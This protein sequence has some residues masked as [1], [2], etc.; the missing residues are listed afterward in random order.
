[1]KR[2][3]LFI[4]LLAAAGFSVSCHKDGKPQPDGNLI[5]L[6][7]QEDVASKALLNNNTFKTSGNRVHVLDVL[8]GFTGSA[9][10]AD[11]N[12]E[13]GG[14]YINDDIVYNGTVVWDYYSGR[15]YPWTADG[16]HQFFGWLSYDT[17][18]NLTADSYFGTE[19]AGNFSV[20]DRTL[21]IPA[22][23]MTTDSDQFDF[24][25][26]N[27]AYY[28]MPRTSTDP[29]NL[30][31]Q[32]LFSAISIQLKNESQD[33]ILVKN[34]TIEG[35]KNKKSAVI[36]FVG[37]PTLTTL[38]ASEEFLDNL[39]YYALHDTTKTLVTDD[40]IDLLTR[41]KNAGTA[42]YRLIWPQT[43]AELAPS[44]VNDLTT[45]PIT[46]SYEYLSDEEHV[47]HTA[48]LRFPEDVSF[49]PGVRYAFTLLFTQKHIQL[50][51]KV[52]PWNYNLNEWSFDEQS[53]SEVTELDFK[54][55]E[56]YD[57]PNKT[58]TIIGGNP[59]KGT[60]RVVNPSGAIWSIEP[61]GDVEYFTIS[62]NHGI[63]DSSNPDY[64]F[65]VIPNLDPSLDRS[66]D[67][68]LRFRF[69]VEFTDGSIHDANSEINRDG[70][71]VI[72]P[73]N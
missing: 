42:E 64:E 36:P 73:K 58:C 57:K 32:H 24:L 40:T 68:K 17:V 19:L 3:I 49:E 44:D 27:T 70:W 72:L 38:S 55:N 39:L 53:I 54:D 37:S 56:G 12:L 23:E 29:V 21:A 45:Y 65:Y 7:P 47:Q 52:N 28:L 1:M 11:G 34:V 2:Y 25:Y 46:V 67:K 26:G 30:P 4:C 15:V 8:S 20:A 35:L 50:T 9:S 66:V 22:R 16:G 13:T 63:V 48:H 14:L 33:D 6:S 61:V 62:P 18:Q 43:A 31:L 60:F 41:Q 59:V 10:W 51:F 5:T 71:T 69:Y